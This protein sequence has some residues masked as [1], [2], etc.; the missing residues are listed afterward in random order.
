MAL[1]ETWLYVRQLQSGLQTVAGGNQEFAY[2]IQYY[3]ILSL[4][5]SQNITQSH[6][7]NWVKTII[8]TGSTG[9]LKVFTQIAQTAP[10]TGNTPIVVTDYEV[11]ASQSISVGGNYVDGEI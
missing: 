8:S 10:A 1:E 5:K 2:Y 4:S 11:G 9:S 3:S 7:N 6:E